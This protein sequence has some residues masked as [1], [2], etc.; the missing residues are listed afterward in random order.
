MCTLRYVLDR[1]S[2]NRSFRRVGRWALLSAFVVGVLLSG[3]PAHAQQE[4]ETLLDRLEQSDRV[5]QVPVQVL[6]GVSKQAPEQLTEAQRRRVRTAR[7]RSGVRAKVPTSDLTIRRSQQQFYGSSWPR[8]DL[9]FRPSALPT[10]A[11]DVNGDGVNDW[12]Y[13]YGNVADNRTADRSDRTPKTLLVFGGNDFGARYYDELYYRDLRPVG[14]F[15]GSEEADAVQPIGSGLRIFR[16]SRHGY[17]EVGTRTGLSGTVSLTTDVNGDGYTDIVSTRP[18]RSQIT[19]VYG[20]QDP[21]DITEQVYDPSYQG[22]QS[23]SYAADDIDDDGNGEIVRLAGEATTY[24]NTGDSLVV[25]V[26]ATTADVADPLSEEQ[27]FVVEKQNLSFASDIPVFLA[28]VDG[29]D[30]QEII[31]KRPSAPPLVFTSSSGVYDATSIEYD[32]PNLAPVGDV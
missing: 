22:T 17:I 6:H 26:F 3:V 13:Q 21:A 9:N 28:N 8:Q 10:P 4:G 23:F 16:G 25:N 11:G 27:E 32:A 5:D 12:I 20:A 19:I 31:L 2:Q 15:V 24:S 1:F 7:A 30:L 29:V 18:S 14:N